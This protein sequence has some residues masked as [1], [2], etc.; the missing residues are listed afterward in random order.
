VIVV[1]GT[2]LKASNFGTDL[3]EGVSNRDRGG[4]GKGRGGT[5]WQGGL[6][7]PVSGGGWGFG[8]SGVVGVGMGNVKSQASIMFC[9][10]D[11]A[12][13]SLP[14]CTNEMRLV[15][16]VLGLTWRARLV[17]GPSRCRRHAGSHWP[18]GAAS[19]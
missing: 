10:L 13:V 2:F 8:G 17:D 18:L 11:V 4:V 16:I 14:M 3:Y 15:G 5:G 9:L 12:I 6:V 7:P 19:E 1:K